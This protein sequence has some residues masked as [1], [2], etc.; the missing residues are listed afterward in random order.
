MDSLDYLCSQ[1]NEY[2]YE[3]VTYSVLDLFFAG[4]AREDAAVAALDDVASFSWI[5]PADV[6]ERELAFPSIREALA[7]YLRKHAC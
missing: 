6:D 1:P 2:V 7:L 3:Q 5:K 4:S